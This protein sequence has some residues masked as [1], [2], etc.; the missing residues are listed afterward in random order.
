MSLRRNV[1][2][3][4]AAAVAVTAMTATVATA[5]P[6]GAHPAGDT[7]GRTYVALGDSYA[8]GF[9]LPTPATPTRT[10]YPGCAQT[11]LD[12]PHRLAAQLKLRLIDASC[13]GA[14]TADFF[15]QQNVLGP[16]PPAQLDV[17]KELQPNLVTV[18]IGGNDLGFSSIA[19][20][21]LA[22]TPAGPLF[23]HPTFASCTAYFTS[24]PGSAD[25]PYTRLAAV[26]IK[27]R[28]ALSAVHKAAPHARIVVIAY[29]AI[30]PNARNTPLGG[31]FAANTIPTTVVNGAPL[32]SAF[33]FT[34]TDVP[35][36][37]GLQKRLD[38]EIA[39]ATRDSGGRYADIY[40]ASLK[41]SACSPE[42]TR[43]VEP[44]VPGGGGFNVLHPSLAGTAAM[45]TTLAP[46]FTWLLTHGQ[47]N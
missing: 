10:R 6:A 46:T 15:T 47:R 38:A 23:L 34:D 21:C 26:G 13:S 11:S 29:P 1:S 41:H 43:W 37:A 3:L 27:V 7:A 44:V 12:Y 22:A 35:F 39:E 19:Q 18:T 33:P 45:A 2:T 16:R 31:C 36:L 42:S 30:A 28:A 5:P 9:G 20:T 8:A 40:N 32:T 14:T 25:N 17:V 4:I 24:Q